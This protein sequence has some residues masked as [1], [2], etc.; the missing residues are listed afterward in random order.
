MRLKRRIIDMSFKFFVKE[1]KRHMARSDVED[2]APP[3]VL[4]K[5]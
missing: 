5:F 1:S 3:E 4:M 2:D